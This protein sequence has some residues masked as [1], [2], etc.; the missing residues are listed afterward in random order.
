[1]KIE[2]KTIACTM[3]VAPGSCCGPE[4]FSSLQAE[5]KF[6]KTALEWNFPLFFTEV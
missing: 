5:Q 4:V 1:M 6:K 2:K 3:E